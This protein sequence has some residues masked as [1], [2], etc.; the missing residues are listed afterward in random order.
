MKKEFK[1]MVVI[2]KD[3][4][5]QLQVNKEKG[6]LAWLLHPDCAIDIKQWQSNHEYIKFASKDEG[7]KVIGYIS[8]NFGEIAK[9]VSNNDLTKGIQVNCVKLIPLGEWI[10]NGDSLQEKEYYLAYFKE[11][12]EVI[13]ESQMDLLYDLVKANTYK[14][15]DKALEQFKITRI[16]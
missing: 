10:D 14:G 16:K 11:P 12:K 4:E 9:F 6:N 15:T 8:K 13:Y 1:H 5:L 2:L 3:N 7:D